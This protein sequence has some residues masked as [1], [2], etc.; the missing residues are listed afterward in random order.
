MHTDLTYDE[1]VA[2]TEKVLIKGRA[3]KADVFITRSGGRRF[4]VKD[5]SKKGFWERSFVGRLIT[6]REARAYAALIGIDGLPRS[7]KRLS[8][9]A[10]AV[11]YLEGKDLGNLSRGEL[12]PGVIRQFER[13]VRDLHARG[14]VHL[15]LHRRSNIL[16]VDGK[17]FV[18]DLASALHPGSI[19]LVGPCLTS[20]IGI[21]DLL[22]LIKMKTIYGPELLSDRERAWLRIRNTVMPS[23][24]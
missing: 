5:Y 1:A 4:V 19:P 11:E 17:V 20:L 21:A 10:F 12:G 2:N 14:W 3:T 7:A 16:L 6:S 9:F 8:P 24:W 15:D 23:K 18:V 13:I 22:S